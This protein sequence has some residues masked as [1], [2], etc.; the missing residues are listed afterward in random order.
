MPDPLS[1]AEVER[2]LVV[3]AHPDDADFGAAGTTATWT[4]TGVEVTYL[5]CTY[6]DQGGFDDTPREQVPAI[7]EAEQRAAAAAVGVSDVRFLTGYHD[8]SLVPTRELQR[9][10][11]RVMRQVRP[12][13]V[14]TQSPERWWDRLGAS[15]PDHLAAGE[16]TIRALY[17]AARNPFAFPEL[18][19]QEGLEPWAVDEAWLMAD[20]RADHAVDIT[21]TFDAKLA[22]LHA[23][24]SQT[25][26]LGDGLEDRLHSWGTK[27]AESAGMSPGRLAEVFRVVATG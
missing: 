5:L 21:D 9:D 22:A 19:T 26:H 14:L 2:V 1:A 16:A 7:R 17:P 20:E 24:A 25:A 27:V 12:R 23:H 18:L 6:G 3:V 4:R 15:H 13:R 8:G 10:I 11:I